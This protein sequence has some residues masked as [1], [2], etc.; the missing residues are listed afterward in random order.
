M[1]CVLDSSGVIEGEL[2]SEEEYIT[3]P[4]VLDELKSSDAVFSI[5]LVQV[6]VFS[7]KKEYVE[8]VIEVAKKS[9]DISRLSKT[10]VACIAL[11]LQKQ[12]TLLTNDFSM[13][14]VAIILGVVIKS[15]RDK[16][17]H[18]FQWKHLCENCAKPGDPGHPCAVCGGRIRTRRKRKKS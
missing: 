14:N 18:I 2:D 8:K 16:I 7:P 1:V 6:S 11:A 13:Q 10:D 17:T 3:V 9:G 15:P 4:E 5:S 12:V